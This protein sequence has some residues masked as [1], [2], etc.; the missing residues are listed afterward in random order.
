M[1]VA[2]ELRGPSKFG[3]GGVRDGRQE[4]C[5]GS[6]GLAGPRHCA[7]RVLLGSEVIWVDSGGKLETGMLITD[8]WGTGFMVH[9]RIW[10]LVVHFV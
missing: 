8:D 10:C 2:S 6:G 9:A 4:V 1:A 3:R 5:R 7:A